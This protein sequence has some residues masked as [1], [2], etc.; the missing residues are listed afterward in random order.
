[1]PYRVQPDGIIECDTAREAVELQ[2]LL[3]AD[4]GGRKRSLRAKGEPGSQSPKAKTGPNYGE[5]WAGLNEDGKKLF[6]ALGG[7]IT[8]L[9]GADLVGRCGLKT[10]DLPGTMIHIRSMAKKHHIDEPILREK[11][12]EG[13]RPVST[14]RL[15]DRVREELKNELTNGS[16]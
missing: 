1:M 5:F 15:A 11:G 14:Y 9:K 4:F 8:P 7:D 6:V 3:A 16:A 10:G 2:G 13:R 12:I